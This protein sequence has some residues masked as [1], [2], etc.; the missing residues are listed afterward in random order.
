M[1]TGIE[2]LIAALGGQ[3]IQ[4]LED[5]LISLLD[6]LDISTMEGDQLDLIGGIVGQDRQGFTDT[7]YRLFL[8]AKIGQ[9]VS[10]TDIERVLST[11]ILLTQATTIELVE[12]FPAEITLYSEI[13]VDASELTLLF[14][15]VRDILAAG[16]NFGGYGVFPEAGTFGFSPTSGGFSTDGTTGGGKFYNK[17]VGS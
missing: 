15:F 4:D 11:W 14:E 13:T 9:N 8:Q 3:Q 10:E 1:A 5:T 12:I 6:R 16:V 7:K 17:Q 2:L